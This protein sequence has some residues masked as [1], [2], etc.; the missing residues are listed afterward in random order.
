MTNQKPD[1]NHRNLSL[2]NVSFAFAVLGIGFSLVALVY[3]GE[4]VHYKW[5]KKIENKYTNLVIS[6]KTKNAVLQTREKPTITAVND[7][8]IIEEK[9]D[10]PAVRMMKERMKEGIHVVSK[11]K[12]AKVIEY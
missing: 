6:N 7:V 8:G 12:K 1:T 9:S 10:E 11:K 3:A 2:K 4:W 5:T